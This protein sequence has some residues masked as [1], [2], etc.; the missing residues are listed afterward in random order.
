MQRNII[1]IDEDKCTG[2]GVCVPDCP[3][4]AIQVIDGKARLVGELLCDGLGACIGNCPEGAISIE[5]RQ[6]EPYDEAAV[7]ENVVRGGEKV[8]RAHLTHLS[9]HNQTAYLNQ[10]LDYLRKNNIPVPETKPEKKETLACGCPGTMAKKLTAA[11]PPDAGTTAAMTPAAA[12]RLG[13][14]PI[15]LHLL[16]P[17][18]PYFEDA[19]L[20]VAA[21]CTAF[22]FAN[23]HER[24]LK[25]RILIMFCPKLDHSQEQYLE[26]M[27]SIL[28]DN[29]I[30]SITI[31][32]MEVPCCGGTVR[33]VEDALSRSGKNIIVKEYTLSL[34][35]QII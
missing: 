23:F 11:T 32:R 3:E 31:V 35:G 7:M 20:L 15:Q 25:D 13:Q 21:D 34:Q 10:A 17:H 18:A 4:G 29:N 16:N 5:M 33:L 8:I 24:F 27:T 26:K 2:C 9:G 12:S 30:K 1:N 28:K 6:A 14:W 22:S 19:D